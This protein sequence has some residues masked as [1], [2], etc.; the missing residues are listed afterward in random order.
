MQFVSILFFELLQDAIGTR[1]ITKPR[2]SPMF[3][4]CWFEGVTIAEIDFEVADHFA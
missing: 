3:W 2:R 1:Q 4:K